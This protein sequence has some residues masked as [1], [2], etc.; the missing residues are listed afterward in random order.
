MIQSSDFTCARHFD[1]AAPDGAAFTIDERW[2]SLSGHGST[3]PA[4]TATGN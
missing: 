4:G 2:F 3:S 1:Q